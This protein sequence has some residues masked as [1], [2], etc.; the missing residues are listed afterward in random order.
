MEE[1]KMKKLLALLL[2]CAMITVAC[3]SC[4]KDE[5]KEKES[6]A[7][8]SA[9]SDDKD[10]KEDDDKDDKKDE[11][12]KKDKE[13]KEDSKKD[14]SSKGSASVE[15]T[16]ICGDWTSEELFGAVISFGED[17][18]MSS[19]FDYSSMM[20]FN[21]DGKLEV[22]GQTCDTEFDGETIKASAEGQ[23]VLSLKR[24]GEKDDSTMDGEYEIAGGM[25]EED[26]ATFGD[27]EVSF[28]IEGEKLTVSAEMGEYTADGKTL[29]MKGGST[30][31]SSDTAEDGEEVEESC[32]YK[33]EGDTLTL[34]MADDEGESVEL[35]RV[36]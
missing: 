16:S 8:S 1:I 7:E 34:I 28:I 13:D 19:S 14:E 35:T 30:I 9:V 6:K 12:S 33:I 10:D 29:V 15:D 31:L 3:A 18:V 36:K 27:G 32:E 26:L 23:E 25:D 11:E 21:K 20:C 2:S 24:K 5:K 22:M 4:D 17:G